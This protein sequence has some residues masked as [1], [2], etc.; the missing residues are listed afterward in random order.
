LSLGKKFGHSHEAGVGK[1]HGYVRISSDKNS[2]KS[3][4]WFSGEAGFYHTTFNHLK[5]QACR[6]FS[7]L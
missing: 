5:K 4:F 3:N 7:A 2:E 6:D 1:G